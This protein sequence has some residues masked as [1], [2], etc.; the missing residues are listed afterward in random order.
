[1]LS[2]FLEIKASHDSQIYKVI[3][4]FRHIF[5][6][7]L[8]VSDD[9]L[10]FKNSLLMKL[11]LGLP[12]NGIQNQ[13]RVKFIEW[14]ENQNYDI[15]ELDTE[16]EN[17]SEE[18]LICSTLARWIVRLAEL[19]AILKDTDLE[20]LE[21]KTKDDQNEN[22]KKYNCN[23]LTWFNA[24]ITDDLEITLVQLSPQI[25]VNS[26]NIKII[27]ID[28]QDMTT[29]DDVNLSFFCKSKSFTYRDI[30][31]N[32]GNVPN[33]HYII[34]NPQNDKT[35]S[36]YN[37]ET[38]YVDEMTDDILTFYSV[39]NTEYTD[40]KNKI[41][42]FAFLTISKDLFIPVVLDNNKT[43]D[44][45]LDLIISKFQSV[46][47]ASTKE[48][49]KKNL[50]WDK[51][52]LAYDLPFSAYSVDNKLLTQ[53]KR[54]ATLFTFNPNLYQKVAYIKNGEL[55]GID[56]K[57]KPVEIFKHCYSQSYEQYRK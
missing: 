39:D 2:R 29:F 35:V 27:V 34:A 3:E 36:F 11:Y 45:Q 12:L 8:G 43:M 57:M 44:E 19:F 30:R 4:G 20:N 25:E 1:M 22:I 42:D 17:I 52:H 23:Y 28:G 7:A 24:P 16:D 50:Y 15:E 10:K 26:R 54:T 6:Y 40:V 46:G 5:K 41:K 31:T 21:S 9:E 51:K 33:K 48:D 13:N 53:S 18:Q 32:L 38:L 47:I 14:V 49:L 55:S 37:E 56:L